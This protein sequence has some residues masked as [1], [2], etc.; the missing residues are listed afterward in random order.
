MYDHISICKACLL[1]RSPDGALRAWRGNALPVRRSQT[2][3]RA[4]KRARS[5]MT[6]RATSKK[7]KGIELCS[8]HFLVWP[9]IPWL[10]P[11]NINNEGYYTVY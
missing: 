2:T 3:Q 1:E 11:D 8:G 9:D 6:Q 7:S 4:V 10:Q 5:A